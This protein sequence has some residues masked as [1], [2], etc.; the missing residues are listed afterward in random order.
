MDV[1]KK[2]KGY[3]RVEEVDV[4]RDF[5]RKTIL[6]VDDEESIVDLLVYHLQK[7]GYNTLQAY[8]GASAV[9]IAL[10]EKPDL[11]LL[12]VM[13]PKMDGISV[14]KRIR[15]S[16][17]VPILMI[18]AKDTE[19]DKV[20]GLEMGADDYIT[21]P[22]QHREVMA[23]IKANLRKAELVAQAEMKTESL[24]NEENLI[25]VGDLTLDLKK[26]EAKVKGEVV[27]LTIKEFEV[28]KY[29]VKTTR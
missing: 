3:P 27:D 22:F 10:K 7:E 24:E 16:L 23:R 6:V 5:N 29:L 8:D 20:V 9:E 11:I 14:C 19:L 13:L 12:D 2:R 17:N 25:V 15:Y 21:K 1:I 4:G 18:S 26:V 28:L